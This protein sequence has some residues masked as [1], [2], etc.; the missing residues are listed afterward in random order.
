M[1]HLAIAAGCLV[2]SGLAVLASLL[3]SLWPDIMIRFFGAPG[4]IVG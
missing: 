3:V 2:A 4:A 1:D